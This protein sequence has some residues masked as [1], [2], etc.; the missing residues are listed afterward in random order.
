[1]SFPGGYFSYLRSILSDA[2]ISKRV[3]VSTNTTWR[4]NKTCQGLTQTRTDPISIIQRDPT[5]FYHSESGKISKIVFDLGKR[6]KIK[7]IAMRGVPGDCRHLKAYYV[8]GSNKENQWNDIEY[9][10]NNDLKEN[11]DWHNYSLPLSFY[12]YYGIFQDPVLSNSFSPYYYFALS[13]VDFIYASLNAF[14][15]CNH[16]SSNAGMKVLLMI[17]VAKG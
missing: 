14:K 8:K 6:I 1:M 9:I 12:R 5:M 15:T 17:L 10:D 4:I 3:T 2:E 7:G 16:R 13:G 11:Y